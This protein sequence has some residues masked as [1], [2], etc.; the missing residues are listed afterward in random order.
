MASSKSTISKLN[1][2]QNSPSFE[3][4]PLDKQPPIFKKGL[5]SKVLD[6]PKKNP[7]LLENYR[8]VTIKCLAPNCR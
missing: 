4:E 5:F 3:L 8:T 7:E 6:P 2:A 1:I